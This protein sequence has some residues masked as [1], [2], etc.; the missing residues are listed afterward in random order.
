[1]TLPDLRRA[2]LAPFRFTSLIHGVSIS[3]TLQAKSK[4]TIRL[5]EAVDGASPAHR[6]VPGG[7]FLLTAGPR[8]GL[9]LWDLGIP[10]P[11]VREE[12]V[13]RATV[14]LEEGEIVCVENGMIE[15]C[16]VGDRIVVVVRTR[17]EPVPEYA[18][19]EYGIVELVDRWCFDRFTV[20][21]ASPSPTSSDPDA[22]CFKRLVILTV[23]S[24]RRG[25]KLE[26]Q[27]ISRD[28]VMIAPREVYD[29]PVTIVV[30]NFV[31]GT[32]GHFTLRWKEPTSWGWV[33][34][35]Y[36]FVL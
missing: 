10:G 20:F 22:F 16:I 12:P 35:T 7:R 21:E 34:F 5:A 33:G 2:A 24:A 32:H 23:G 30:V 6:I 28:C 15:M 26:C 31:K 11:L 18:F 1:M 36:Y 4:V 9:C 25:H 17:W 14:Q 19:R 8:S 27:L 3:G 13:L 29:E